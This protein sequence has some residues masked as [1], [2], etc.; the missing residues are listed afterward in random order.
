MSITPAQFKNRFPE[1]INVSVP[2]IRVFIADAE[3]EMNESKWGDR[4]DKGLSYLT[5]HFLSIALKTETGSPASVAAVA[6]KSIGD[7][8]VSFANKSSESQVEAYYQSTVYGQEYWS[9][10]RFVGLGA[11]AV[12]STVLN[13]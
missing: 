2:R 13:V 6:S 1:F 10:L 7:V 12:S 8:S 9:M 11:V 4:Y 3:L 5:A